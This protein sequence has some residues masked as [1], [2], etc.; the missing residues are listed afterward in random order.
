L[1]N[2]HL[3]HYHGLLWV[4]CLEE[5]NMCAPG[6]TVKGLKKSVQ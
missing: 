5:I 1:P 4:E 2:G 6:Y 3:I